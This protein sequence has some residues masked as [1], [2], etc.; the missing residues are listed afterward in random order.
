MAKD[1]ILTVDIGASTVKV[2]E[3][4]V[5][6][7]LKLE[8]CG[9]AELGT[10][11]MRDQNRDLQVAA[12][13]REVM[14]ENGIK[15]GRAYVTVGG[16]AVF[17]RFVTCPALERDK[18][19]QIVQHEAV[20]NVPFPIDEVIW[21]YQAF[22]E[23][24]GELRVMLAAIKAEQVE[25]LSH[26]VE[27]AGLDPE[28]IDVAPMALCSAVKN[29]GAAS[30][31]CTLVADIG[32]RTTGLIFIE[33]GNVFMRS[34]P[35]AGNTFTQ[36]IADD[37]NLSFEEAEQLKR[38]YADGKA[39][40]NA[41][42]IAASIQ[43]CVIRMIGELNRS[44]SFYRTQQGGQKPVKMLLAGGSSVLPGIADTLK[45]RLMLEVDSFDPLQQVSGSVSGGLNVQCG[46]LVGLALRLAGK[47]TF[48]INLMPERLIRQKAFRRKQPLIVAS[49][50]L[51]AL[52]AGA[53]GMH[54]AQKAA[55]KQ[56]ELDGVA[57]RVDELRKVEPEL[58]KLEA[59]VAKLS[60]WQ[61]KLL[62]LVDD[63]TEWMRI[64]RAIQGAMP[65]DTVITSLK[66]V[67]DAP[68]T[69]LQI[70]GFAY[71]DRLKEQKTDIPGILESLKAV[72]M[73]DA[74][75]TNVIK[76][77][78]SGKFAD[79]FEIEIALKEPVES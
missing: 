35:V 7:G 46:E 17:S 57:G 47:S 42:K 56:V 45:Q 5:A 69:S 39:G 9:V 51:I 30:Q 43:A 41:D 6:G 4:T 71:K 55:V 73:F 59:S 62:G 10:E 33:D 53:W 32:A 50:A 11:L 31:G 67:G 19:H 16:Q 34:V 65:A 14:Q 1:R 68:F 15:P 76:Q 20:Q 64:V 44:I 36:R 79:E 72:E 52:T 24:D 58:K 26:A 60:G 3:F 8:K 78:V 74:K 77:N 66:P 21:D 18:L 54:F 27:M 13:L 12:V 28:V 37:L 48:K 75:K 23:I 25:G 49:A 61:D 38:Q 70:A 2:A 40:E 63:R 29:S 22:D